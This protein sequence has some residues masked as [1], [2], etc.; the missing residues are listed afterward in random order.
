MNTSQ[1]GNFSD[2]GSTSIGS[3]NEKGVYDEP[4][5][6]T[7]SAKPAFN[8]DEANQAGQNDQDTAETAA[9]LRE[10]LSG[11]KTDLD[12][13]LAK[14]SSLTDRELKLARDQFMIKCGSV[15]YAAKG[16]AAQATKQFNDGVECT[17]EYVKERP[18]QSV[19]LA[20]GVGLLIGAILRGK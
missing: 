12:A 16:V 19:A 15:R 13:L 7:T 10:E 4:D 8:G 18:L 11:L 3:A 1:T 2:N 6:S 14:A 9:S 5:V 20:T 17:S